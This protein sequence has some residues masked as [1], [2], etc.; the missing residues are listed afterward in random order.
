MTTTSPN[1]KNELTIRLSEDVAMRLEAV[2]QRQKRPA[3]LV[4]AALLEKYLPRLDAG[5]KRVNIPYA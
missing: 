4:A 5:Q 2:A 1:E 3:H